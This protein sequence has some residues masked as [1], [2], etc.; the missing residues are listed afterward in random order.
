MEQTV[1]FI[2]ADELSY[3]VDSDVLYMGDMKYRNQ[4]P[5][6]GI[7][8]YFV[9]LT[10][11]THILA[12][13][14]VLSDVP[15]IHIQDVTGKGTVTIS[16][17]HPILDIDERIDNFLHHLPDTQAAPLH[18]PQIYRAILGDHVEILPGWDSD[19]PA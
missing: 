5:F 1:S 11:L 6:D 3:A 4:Y 10:H 7:V 14:L 12:P 18:I 2:Q 8:Q 13:L 17:S 19:R 16:A 9:S 15:T